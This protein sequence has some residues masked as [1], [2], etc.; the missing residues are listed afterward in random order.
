ME[1]GTNGMEAVGVAVGK[2]ATGH[3]GIDP[4]VEEVEDCQEVAGHHDVQEATVP[5]AEAE[6]VVVESLQ[7]SNRRAVAVFAAAAGQMLTGE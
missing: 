5:V 7:S 4:E 6:V 1:A 2:A 3:S